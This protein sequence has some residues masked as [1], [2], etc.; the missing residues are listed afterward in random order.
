MLSVQ[1]FFFLGVIFLLAGTSA[2]ETP[3]LSASS[4]LAFGAL[5][6]LVHLLASWRA[7]ASAH[8]PGAWFR[9]E[10]Q[11]FALA[12]ASFVALLYGLDL[13]YWLQPLT[14]FDKTEGLADLAGLALFFALL[15]LSWLAGRS[16]FQVFFGGALIDEIIRISGESHEEK[17]L[18]NVIAMLTRSEERR[19]G[20]E[21][22][23]RWSPYH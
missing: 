7:F 19:V 16:R 4:S 3:G 18:L 5:I 23:S 21:C 17:Y 15:S 20:K 2:P 9:A 11:A 1:L 14:F 13:K 8:S 12:F 22:R 6:C 10:R